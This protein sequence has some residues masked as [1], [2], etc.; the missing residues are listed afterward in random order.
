MNKITKILITYGV[1]GTA[2]IG[3]IIGVSVAISQQHHSKLGA[4][5][6]K[7]YK[8]QN[9]AA[10]SNKNKTLASTYATRNLSFD[11]ITNWSS[12]N[13]KRELINK[14]LLTTEDIQNPKFDKK[15]FLYNGSKPLQALFDSVDISSIEMTSYA[16]D[17]N[18]TLFLKVVY[19]VT[20]SMK[21]LDSTLGDNIT[22]IY[23][24]NGF[25]T[26]P[27]NNPYATSNTIDIA[28]NET[29]FKDFANIQDLKQAYETIN[30]ERDTEPSKV[31]DW[32]KKYF[33]ISLA[34]VTALDYSS[35]ALIFDSNSSDK[36]TIQYRY[37]WKVLVATDNDLTA[38]QDY[39]NQNAPITNKQIE[40]NFSKEAK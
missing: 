4:K 18:G 22:E 28:P 21:E 16:N 20:K 39:F 8:L 37:G 15:F 7:N 30:K 34:N 33:D 9:T 27:T 36:F 11:E 31:Q 24:L 19:P 3:G 2:T 17:L 1:I 14:K 12:S 13:W 10:L 32:F 23:T 5:E 26:F 38:K 29:A 35:L 6:L 40:Y 25:D